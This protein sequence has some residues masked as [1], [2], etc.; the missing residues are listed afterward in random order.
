MSLEVKGQ[1][2][3]ILPVQSG[4]S[5][6]GNEWSKQEFVIETQE[7]FPKK[8][9]FTLFGDKLTLLNGISVGDVINVAFNLESR[10]FNGRWFHNINAWRITGADAAQDAAP[11]FAPDNM[12]PPPPPPA[13]G[14]DAPPAVD[15][16]PF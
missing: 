4:V 9:C 7:Q 15:D 1:L 6:A 11:G 5:K 2:L 12:P 10:E 14:S 3:Q 8:V 13:G 16:L